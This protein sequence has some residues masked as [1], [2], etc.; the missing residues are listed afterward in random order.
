M[1]LIRLRTAMWLA[2][3]WGATFIGG[4]AS[5]RQLATAQDAP[6]VAG[7]ARPEWK[8]GDT[9]Q[10]ETVTERM[11][12]REPESGAGASRIRWKFKVSDV[13]KI[14]N[15]DCWRIDIECLANGRLKPASA[16]WVDQETLFLRQ[17]QT[18]LPVAG[19]L[20]T[21]QETYEP[22]EAG[23]SPVLPPVNVVPVSLP[24]FIAAAPKGQ[25]KYT[26]QPTGQAKDAA[27]RV[28]FIHAVSQEVQPATAKSLQYVPQAVS[29]SL[30]RAPA[31]EVHLASPGQQVLQVWQKNRPWPVFSQAGPTKSWLIVEPAA[32]GSER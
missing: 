31:V 12:D 5:S 30:E 21:V 2:F 25:F 23:H 18:Q 7:L 8:K 22:G 19:A 3:L 17:F 14:S 27:T 20:R 11:Q 10:I 26:S 24:A 16:I 13:E 6:R 1:W 4:H 15:R 32:A 9:W 28:K 29:K